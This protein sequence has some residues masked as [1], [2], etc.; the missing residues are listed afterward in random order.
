MVHHNLKVIFQ[1]DSQES[2]D[3]R[4][5]QD[6]ESLEAGDLQLSNEH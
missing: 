1:K 2:D 6:D 3:L 4:M 5:I